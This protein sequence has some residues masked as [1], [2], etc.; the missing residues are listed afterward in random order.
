MYVIKW[1]NTLT[2]EYGQGVPTSLEIAKSWT[3][4]LNKRYPYITHIIVPVSR[5]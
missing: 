2:Q 5:V 4:A 1:Q 3:D